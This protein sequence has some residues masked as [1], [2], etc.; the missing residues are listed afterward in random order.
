[1]VVVSGAQN[2]R[3]PTGE[4][5]HQRDFLEGKKAY[6]HLGDQDNQPKPNVSVQ[7]DCG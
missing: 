1:M 5:H 3:R 2:V 6:D 4:C 7:E